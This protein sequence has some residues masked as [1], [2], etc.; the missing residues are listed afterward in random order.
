MG[1]NCYLSGCRGACHLCRY[2]NMTSAQENDLTPINQG[3][4]RRVQLL[5]YKGD[6]LPS[7]KIPRLR[8]EYN[9][10]VRFNAAHSLFRQGCI[11]A[12]QDNSRSNGLPLPTSS[13]LESF[14]TDSI[15]RF[16]VKS[17]AWGKKSMDYTEA[18]RMGDRQASGVLETLGAFER[19]DGRRRK[20]MK[21]LPK[22]L[23]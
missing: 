11:A 23:V 19:A 21:F 15:W 6:M 10:C 9:N 18:G 17:R 1:V 3:F 7:C 16:A 5:A 20:L 13:F 8:I 14:G 12:A 2:R 4:W 22:L